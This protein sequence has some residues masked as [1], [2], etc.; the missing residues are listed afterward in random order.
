MFLLESLEEELR[1]SWQTC[2]VIQGC[3]FFIFRLK[4]YTHKRDRL[5]LQ[6]ACI[7]CTI[8]NI[9]VFQNV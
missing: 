2:D 3:L 8:L 9:A 1:M 4:I 5:I 7:C 6:S